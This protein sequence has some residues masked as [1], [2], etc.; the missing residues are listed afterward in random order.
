VFGAS[1]AAA[2]PDHVSGMVFARDNTADGGFNRWTINGVAYPDTMA[3]AQPMLTR[4]C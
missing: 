2:Q 3:M 4:P 1:Q